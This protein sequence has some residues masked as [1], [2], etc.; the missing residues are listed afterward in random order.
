[1]NAR[2]LTVLLGCCAQL[3][4]LACGPGE[5]EP[6]L[7]EGETGAGDDGGDR[8]PVDL[9]TI[10][11]SSC[12][13]HPDS[14]AQFELT[15]DG[16]FYN[17]TGE[18]GRVLCPLIRDR[19]SGDDAWTVQV[20]VRDMHASADVSC[21]AIARDLE[22]EIVAESAPVSTVG[23]GG[24]QTVTLEVPNSEASAYHYV[25][26]SVPGED[27]PGHQSGLASFTLS[28]VRFAEPIN[29]KSHPGLLA[30]FND[31]LLAAPVV[32]DEL[33]F[34]ELYVPDAEGLS[35]ISLPL[36]RDNPDELPEHVRVHY[37][38]DGGILICSLGIYD[39][40]GVELDVP[41]GDA[42]LDEP[43][44]TIEIPVPAMPISDGPHVLQCI[45]T[46]PV[47]ILAYELDEP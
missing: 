16:Q 42:A 41:A 33:G 30:Q 9:K 12:V 46:G 29:S 3:L 45:A 5:A 22:G 17:V 26:C 23:S 37:F 19:P 14:L 40:A 21:V 4:A 13:T 6:A 32:F 31:V 7:S 20:T 35:I 10:D 27:M 43:F 15:L 18:V 39:D 25:D 8:V 24:A 34:A 47:A 38:M 44:G 11:A 28:E 2:C 36:V 1:M